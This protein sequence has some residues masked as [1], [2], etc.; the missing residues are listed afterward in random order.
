MALKISSFGMSNPNMPL[1]LRRLN[2]HKKEL[3]FLSLSLSLSLHF[4]R[5][6][7][8]PPLL[9]WHH[10]LSRMLNQKLLSALILQCLLSCIQQFNRYWNPNSG[11]LLFSH[12]LI[13][14]TLSNVGVTIIFP[15]P[16]HFLKILHQSLHRSF[17]FHTYPLQLILNTVI[18]LQTCTQ[19]KRP[20]PE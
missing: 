13:S 8:L 15:I 3:P 5:F 12:L 6:S 11:S 4:F 17:L 7:P 9:S 20:H 18:M 2:W 16:Y 14:T 1:L 10:Y 19:H